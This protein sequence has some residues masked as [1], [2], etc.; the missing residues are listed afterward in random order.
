VHR[1][2]LRRR[3]CALIAVAAAIAFVGIGPAPVARA[4][5]VDQIAGTGDTSSALTVSWKQGLLGLDNHTVVGKR[6]PASPFAFMYPDFENLTLHVTQTDHLVHQAITV[7][8][9]GGV[10][11]DQPF[12]SNFLQMMQC[13][14]DAFTGPDPEACEYGSAGMLQPTVVNSGIGSREGRACATSKPDTTNPPA[15]ASGSGPGVGCDPSEPTSP[16]HVAPCPQGQICLPG[17]YSVPFIPVGSTDKAYG[18][19]TEFFDQFNTNEIQQAVT[20]VD[21]KGQQSFQIVTGPEAPSLGCGLKGH[22][23]NVRGCWLVIVPRG[24]YNPNGWKA[25]GSSGVGGDVNESPLGAANWAQRIQIHLDFEGVPNACRIG[26]A[27]ERPLVGSELV[28]RAVFSWQ[29]ALNA[30][31]NCRTIFGYTATNEPASTLQL[32]SPTGAG[33]AFTTIPVGSEVTRSGGT[34]T[35]TPPLVYAPVTVSAITFGFYI[36]QSTGVIST[37]IKLT[38][39]LLAKALT[40]S[41]RFDLPDVDGKNPGPDWAK[42]NPDFIT[43]DPEFVH[44]NPGINTPPANVPLAPLVTVEHSSVNM[45]VWAWI[46]ADPAARSWLEGNKDENGMVI[47]QNYLNPTLSLATRAIDSFPRADP[48]CFN[49]GAVGERN[50]GRCTLDL[51]PYARS[52]DDAATHIRAG[53][54]PL[55]AGWDPNKLAPNGQS[56]W[57][58][59]G[60]IEP[61]GQIFMWGVTTSSDVAN[62]GLVPA[63]LCKSDGTS[64]V[65]ASATTVATALSTATPDS[66]GLLHINP[67]IPGHGGYP[68][69]TV[70]YAAVRTDL[71]VEPLRDYAALLRFAAG[72]GQTPGVLPGQLPRGYLPLPDYLKRQ[73]GEAAAKLTTAAEFLV[74]PPPPTPGPPQ[75]TT[76]VQPPTPA[77]LPSG[78]YSTAKAVALP[79]RFTPATPLGPVRW[80]L[81]GV[82]VLGLAGAIGGPLVRGIGRHV[83]MRSWRR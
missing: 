69:V 79:Q 41:Y 70:T 48:T 38:P 21:G 42:N 54:N 30:A 49:T 77:P 63:D 59:S 16:D 74:H 32:T 19:S 11:T 82:L 61:A 46:L 64:C 72:S 65:D 56:G 25:D 52:F 1:Q 39:R 18:Q 24:T 60:G 57:W 73:T 34:P 43:R 6:D 67:A 47:N 20:G 68:L 80:A 58:S 23:G 45:Q 31:A 81:L 76:R 40:Q 10:P 13:Y 78:G 26:Q 33:L 8:W 14:G 15:A 53:N 55:G 62:L 22:D 50:P 71:G 4:D 2:S 5:G 27:K 29:L 66:S 37:H 36:S 44:L 3:L 28:A 7:T 9:S 75:P 83:V 17:Q 35:Q 51:L 12:K